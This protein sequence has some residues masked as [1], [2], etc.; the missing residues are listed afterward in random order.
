M[1]DDNW[2]APAIVPPPS[3]F[4]VDSQRKPVLYLPDGRILVKFVTLSTCP[5]ETPY[6]PLCLFPERKR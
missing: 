6:C 4:T 1:P 5:R 2:D 3:T